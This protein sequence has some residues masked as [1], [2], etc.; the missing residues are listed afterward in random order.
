MLDINLLYPSGLMLQYFV[1]ADQIKENQYFFHMTASWG[2]LFIASSRVQNPYL[3]IK[4]P[5][6]S[7]SYTGDANINLRL[8]FASTL[9][10]RS[11][12]LDRELLIS[13]ILCQYVISLN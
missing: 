6:P 10:Q 3:T 9:M 5:Y 13:N 1:I 8:I 4:P 12:C 7:S 11:M 2:L